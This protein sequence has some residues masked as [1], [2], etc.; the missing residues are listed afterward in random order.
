[1][2]IVRVMMRPENARFASSASSGEREVR[3]LRL[4]EELRLAEVA[5]DE[6]LEVFLAR[7]NLRE[8]ALV[9]GGVRRGGAHHVAEVVEGAAG[10]RR[11]E[12]DHVR[13]ETRHV[14]EHHVVDLRVVVRD[15]LRNVAARHEVNDP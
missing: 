13:A 14:V 6:L 2:P 8:V 9:L 3:E 11:V 1:M 7:K 15:A 4:V 10:H 5:L 12:V